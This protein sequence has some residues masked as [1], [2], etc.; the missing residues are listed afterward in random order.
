MPKP[1]RLQPVTSL[2]SEMGMLA[3]ASSQASHLTSKV[4]PHSKVD[5]RQFQLLL[6][7]SCR[8]LEMR[9]DTGK[10]TTAARSENTQPSRSDVRRNR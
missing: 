10:E 7:G 6:W 8:Q 9:F 2:L 1:T 3:Y 4:A 5:L